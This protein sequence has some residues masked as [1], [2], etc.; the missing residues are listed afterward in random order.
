M[1]N[2]DLVLIFLYVSCFIRVKSAAS[3]VA[4]FLFAISVNVVSYDYS[5]IT[6]NNYDYLIFCVIYSLLCLVK[7][8]H[9]KLSV[10]AMVVFY[11]IMAWDYYL[12]PVTETMLYSIYP[13]VSFVL[14]LLL[15]LTITIT[16]GFKD[17]FYNADHC[18]YNDSKF[19]KTHRKIV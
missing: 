12:N 2:V 15:I 1:G 18:W 13:T 4:L 7:D 10:V 19:N 11:Y 9:I 5:Y 17:G 16:K 14:N 6:N 8:K 3:F